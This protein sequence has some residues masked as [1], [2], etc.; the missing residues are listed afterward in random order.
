MSI[1]ILKSSMSA[2]KLLANNI[3]KVSRTNSNVMV[4]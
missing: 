1:F 4:I 2:R 3:G